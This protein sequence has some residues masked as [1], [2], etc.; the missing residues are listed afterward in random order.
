VTTNAQ[1]VATVGSWVL[2]TTVGSNTL[3]ATSGALFPVTFTA[4]GTAGVAAS[5][6]KSAGDNQTAAIGAP[7]PV[8]PSVLVKDANGNVKPDVTV[9]FAV[10]SGGGSVTGATPTSNA[11]GIATVGSWTL[12]VA[13]PN[14]LTASAPG[15]SSVTFSALALAA[16]CAVRGTHTIGTT[17]NGTLASSDCQFSD[18]SFVDFYTTTVAQANA[19]LFTENAAFDTYLELA[20]PDGTPIGENDDAT[21]VTTNSAVKALLP[22]GTYLL[23][24]GSY[25][26]NIFGDYTLTS[27]TTTTNVGNCELVFVVKNVSTNQNIEATDCPWTQ[28]PSAP[29]YADGFF[30]FLRAGDTVTL[31]MSSSVVDSYLEL[32]RNGGTRVASND[33]KDA[34]SKDAQLTYTA[35]ASDYYAIFTRTAVASQTGA[36]TLTIQ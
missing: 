1:G 5:L 22:P 35:V 30:I 12:G 27:T 11:S 8:P 29:I 20:F 16:Q 17:T 24:P 32:V 9:T 2:G 25:A 28:P 14:T 4:T 21:D 36:Y 6:T 15:V 31:T 13:G 33:N 34:T 7:V 23:G 19:Y 18:G 26:P 3:T 10:T